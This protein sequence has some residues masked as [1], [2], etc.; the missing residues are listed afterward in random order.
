MKTNSLELKHLFFEKL[1]SVYPEDELESLFYWGTEKILN[2]GRL[3]M[4][5]NPEFEI[6]NKN[7]KR[8]EHLIGA[9]EEQMPIQYFFGETLF[10]DLP[11]KVNSDVLIPRP[12]T[13]EL[14]MEIVQYQKAYG[15]SNHPKILDIGTG[16]GCIA[17]ALKTMLPTAE[18]FA[19]DVSKKALAVA[20][21]NAQLNKVAI[22]FVQFDILSFKAYTSVLED[23]LI[24]QE[25][26]IIVSNPPYVRQL[27]R[28]EMNKN[29]LN[30]EPELA[31]FVDDGNALVFY[32]AIAEFALKRLKCQGSLYF[33]IN[34]Y[35]GEEMKHLLK[36]LGFNE[37]QL[38]KDIYGNDRFVKALMS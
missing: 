13:E 28:K 33:E 31:L 8:F 15:L 26:D 32:K 25:F 5:L 1:S 27:E 22:N 16:S 18:V 4:A 29:V 19:L 10:C 34:Q 21:N 9:L 11:F 7:Y 20:R 37:I 24:D 3:Q 2:M 38:N 35:L 6:N 12:E 23:N 36:D 30:F 17:I 14:V